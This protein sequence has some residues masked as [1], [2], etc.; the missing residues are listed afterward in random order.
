MAD[1][2]LSI[3]AT[4]DPPVRTLSPATLARYGVR[5]G[6]E[7]AAG[8]AAW[9]AIDADARRGMVEYHQG[10]DRSG[11]DWRAAYPTQLGHLSNRELRFVLSRLTADAGG[12]VVRGG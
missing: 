3:E 11:D 2:V 5:D 8:I 9:E 12:A 7:L 1:R 4:D 6:D 10:G